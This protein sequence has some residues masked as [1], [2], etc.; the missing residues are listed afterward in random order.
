MVL[1]VDHIGKSFGKKK[2]LNGVSFEIGQG[3][4]IGLVG[5]NG[6][7]KST[8]MK[9]IVGELGADQGDI[10]VS[11]KLGYCPQQIELIPQLTV[12]EHFRYFAGAYSLSPATWS[13]KSESLMDFFN[14][15]QYRAERVD[16]LSGGTKQKLNLSLALL[17]E[18]DLLILDEPYSGFDW[19]TYQRFWSLT[20]SLVKE[21][22]SVLVVTHLLT[23]QE[24]F[25]RV[26][27][28]E[29][30]QVK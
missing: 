29:K 27:E 17:H 13:S 2:V 6:S 16:T 28:M 4:L 8:L 5:E 25:D 3:Q 22:C 1:N 12:D 15:S 18:P 23:D 9:I 26:Y 30:G 7:G 24:A 10:K 20:S 21:G 11:G 14:F 19:D